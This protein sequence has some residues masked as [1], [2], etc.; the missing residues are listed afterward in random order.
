[1]IMQTQ[2]L[3]FLLGNRHKRRGL[4]KAVKEADCVIAVSDGVRVPTKR[5]GSPANG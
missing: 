4:L 5:S 3:P 2:H 1:V